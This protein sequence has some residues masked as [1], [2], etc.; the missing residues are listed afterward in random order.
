MENSTILQTVVKIR[1][2]CKKK[3]QNEQI[4]EFYSFFNEYPAIFFM[5]RDESMNLETLKYFLELKHQIEIGN[6]KQEDMDKIIGQIFYDK[7]V[8]IK[9]SN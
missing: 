3:T 4:N 9:E 2:N 8:N 6:L 1:E 5:A 7:Y